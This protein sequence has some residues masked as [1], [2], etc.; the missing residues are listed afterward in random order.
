MQVGLKM[1]ASGVCELEQ[2]QWRGLLMGWR[3][4]KKEREWAI[5]LGLSLGQRK[6]AWVEGI[7]I[8][9]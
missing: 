4:E 7:W 5:A 1:H 3:K 6:W 8:K 9:W 2:K